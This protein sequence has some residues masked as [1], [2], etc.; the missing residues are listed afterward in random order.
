MATGSLARRYARALMEIGT[1]DGNYE[2][3]G[4]DVRNVATVLE[5]SAELATVFTSPAFPHSERAQIMAAII[6]R[7]GACKVV[8]N[9]VKLLLDRQRMPALPAIARELEQMIDE[10]AG[11]VA[12]VITSAA[13]LTADEQQ[14]VIAAVEKLSGKKVKAEIRNDPEILGGVVCK[15]GDLV[16]DGSLRTITSIRAC[17]SE[18][19]NK[20]RKPNANQGRRDQRHHPQTDRRLRQ[21]GRSYRDRDGANGG[22]RH[23]ACIWPGRGD[24][25]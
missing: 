9:F 18:W 15:V 12:A 2:R 13:R 6:A 10:K 11:R 17:A 20:H 24:G 7:L 16:Y 14:K 4:R 3:I 22:R 5:S 23:R 8:V 19:P 25:G 1:E 21:Q